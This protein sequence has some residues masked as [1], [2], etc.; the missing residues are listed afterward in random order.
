MNI[1]IVITEDPARNPQTTKVFS[2]RVKAYQYANLISPVIKTKVF[3]LPI[4]WTAAPGQA[5]NIIY[6]GIS[7][8]GGPNKIMIYLGDKNSD[9]INYFE[10]LR[11]QYLDRYQRYLKSRPSKPIEDYYF[12]EELQEDLEEDFEEKAP[13]LQRD[14]IF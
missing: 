9:A 14:L 1:Y 8:G 5:I 4:G 2:A 10:D 11:E 6:P 12:R 13:M 3:A 7:Y